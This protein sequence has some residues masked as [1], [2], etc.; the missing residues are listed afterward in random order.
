MASRDIVEKCFD[1]DRHKKVKEMYPCSRPLVSGEGSR[2]VIA[3]FL[4][5]GSPGD[6]RA[7]RG[8]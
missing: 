4:R 1:D 6:Q 8:R 5:S 7:S 3:G 2:V